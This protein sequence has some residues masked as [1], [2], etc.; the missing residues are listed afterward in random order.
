[1]SALDKAT[2]HNVFEKVMKIIAA[3]DGIFTIIRFGVSKNGMIQ[4]PSLSYSDRK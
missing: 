1:M 4:L 2:F 3:H